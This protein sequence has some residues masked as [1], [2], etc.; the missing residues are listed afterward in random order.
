M[1]QFR[2]IGTAINGRQVLAEFEASG[3]K[4]AKQKAERFSNLRALQFKSLDEKVIYQY[5]ARKNGSGWVEGEQ[6]AY[7]DSDLQNALLKYGYSDIKISKKRTLWK[8]GVPMIDVINFIRLSADLLKQKLTYDEILTLLYEDTTNTRLK[9]I[10]KQ[11]QKDL[12]DGKEGREVYRKHEDVF[13]KFASYML[14]VATTSGNITEI[15]DSTA[16]FLERDATFKKNLR[17]SLMMPAITVLAIIGVVL[18]YVG[19]IFPATAEMFLKFDIDLPPM[20]AATLNM[21]YWLSDWWIVIVLI[22]GGLIGGTISYLNSERGKLMFDRYVIQVPIIGDLF[23]KSSIEIFS[24]VF[25][26]LYSGSGQ[27]IEVI[28][29]ASEACRNKWME[30]QIKEVGIRM[31]LDDGK[32][33]VESLEA[34][35]VFTHTALSRF[36]LGAESGSLK[37]NALQLAEYY[38]IQTKYKMESLIETINLVINM[39]IMIALIG[40]TIVSSEAAVIKP[41]SP[42]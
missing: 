11:I 31:M 34:T 22:F 3:V 35:G 4:E 37:A 28:R 20:T 7:T 17:R 14:G 30:K 27:N 38:E 33:L 13:G 15:F 9:E 32:G 8:P 23:H 25:Y 24:R 12:R 18:F 26:T 40:I 5:K 1:S 16:T 29:I 41:K 39:F 19:Y 21:S 6:E 36:K 2:Y 42:F 10:I